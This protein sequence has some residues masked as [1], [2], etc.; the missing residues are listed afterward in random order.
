MPSNYNSGLYNSAVYTYTVVIAGRYDQ[1]DYG[2]GAYNSPLYAAGGKTRFGLDT[3]LKNFPNDL[4]VVRYTIIKATDPLLVSSESQV[5]A[6][7]NLEVVTDPLKLSSLVRFEPETVIDAEDMSSNFQLLKDVIRT[8]STEEDLNTGPIL[9]FDQTAATITELKDADGFALGHQAR[10]DS[11]NLSNPARRTFP[12][13]SKP[14]FVSVLQDSGWRLMAG[15]SSGET[16]ELGDVFRFGRQFVVFPASIYGQETTDRRL[17]YQPYDE[18]KLLSGLNVGITTLQELRVAAGSRTVEA[19]ELSVLVVVDS[20]K[21]TTI[22]LYDKGLNKGLGFV[23]RIPSGNRTVTKRV[24]IPLT[25]EKLQV[26]LSQK[27]T[28]VEIRV[29]GTWG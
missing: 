4:G 21:P 23:L 22:D 9:S 25:S 16:V 20:T 11:Q 14:S 24:R 12:D 8:S 3:L 26:Q 2:T 1:S 28:S 18:P 27:C 13:R 10:L 6:L 5:T 15:S 29:L 7:Y 19:V 17:L